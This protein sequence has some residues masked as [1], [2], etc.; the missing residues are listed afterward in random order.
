MTGDVQ[1]LS[2]GCESGA[3]P[4]RW[5]QGHGRAIPRYRLHINSDSPTAP[6]PPTPH[7]RPPHPGHPG[8][9]PPPGSTPP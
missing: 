8:H 4:D 6:A 5:P 1:H 9:P 2:R 7:P 3:R